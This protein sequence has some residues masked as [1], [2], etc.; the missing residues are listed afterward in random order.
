M[1]K[2]RIRSSNSS[3]RLGRARQHHRHAR[4]RPRRRSCPRTTP[5]N[6]AITCRARRPAAAPGCP[7][8]HEEQLALDGLVG[9]ELG[10]RHH[11]DELVELL[12]DLLQRSGLHVHHDRDAAEALVVGGCHGQRE[13]VEPPP[14]EQAGDAGEHAGLV[15]DHGRDDVV[16]VGHRPASMPVLPARGCRACCRR[17]IVP[18]RPPRAPR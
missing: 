18:P 11:V 3:I 15:L 6:A 13:D 5:T 4:R 9:G 14:A 12:H 7:D 1:P 8:G 10:D 16:P 17:V 2:G